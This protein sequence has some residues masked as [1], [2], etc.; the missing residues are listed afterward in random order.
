MA[1]VGSGSEAS[2]IQRR[3]RKVNNPSRATR[4]V[5]SLATSSPVPSNIP[6]KKVAEKKIP[7]VEEEDQLW[8]VRCILDERTRG[9][10][11]E[12]LCDWVDI[13]PATGK[14]YEPEWVGQLLSRTI[15]DLC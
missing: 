12:Y 5:S 13:D 10:V 14:R 4:P 2:P 3:N 6:R 15:L 11:L 9:G 8:A 1:P 7:K